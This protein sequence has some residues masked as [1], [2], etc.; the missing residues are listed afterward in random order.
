MQRQSCG[1]PS[2]T[3]HQDGHGISKSVEVWNGR[4]GIMLGGSDKP[5]WQPENMPRLEKGPLSASNSHG[6]AWAEVTSFAERGRGRACTS[7]LVR[8]ARPVMGMSA[9]LARVFCVRIIQANQSTGSRGS[10]SIQ[11]SSCFSPKDEGQ[12]EREK[13]VVPARYWKPG[14][15]P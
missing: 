13:R 3:T 7:N 5:S 15:Q 14:I 1:A 2:K 9:I 10:G 11:T 6:F 4:S 12:G 8:F